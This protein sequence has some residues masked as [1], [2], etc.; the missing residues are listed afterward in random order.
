M[1]ELLKTYQV[2]LHDDEVLECFKV[3]PPPL[4][5]GELLAALMPFLLLLRVATPVSGAGVPAGALCTCVLS[6]S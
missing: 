6:G 5:F 4:P 1:A 2:A 3:P